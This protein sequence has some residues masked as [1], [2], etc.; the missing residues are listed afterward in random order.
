MVE[1]DTALLPFKCETPSSWVNLK[2]DASHSQREHQETMRVSREH[3]ELLPALICL[4]ALQSL[5]TET[6]SK[7]QEWKG[8]IPG[9]D[10]PFCHL[11]LLFAVQKWDGKLYLLLLQISVW[12]IR[13]RDRFLS[14]LSEGLAVT[15]VINYSTKKIHSVAQH[16]WEQSHRKVYSREI[17]GGVWVDYTTQKISQPQKCFW[18][19]KQV[20]QRSCW[21]LQ[22]LVLI[23]QDV[24]YKL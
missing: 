10:G 8:M 18:A 13:V 1:T 14:R 4:K 3:G 7:E 12:K 20:T 15:I 5:G 6:F 19:S 23:L 16:F 21:K 2:E 17:T 11:A 22:S 9:F 24:I